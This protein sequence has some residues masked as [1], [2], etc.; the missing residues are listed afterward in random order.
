MYAVRLPSGEFIL[1]VRLSV[2]SNPQEFTM[3]LL[4]LFLLLPFCAFANNDTRPIEFP[5]ITSEDKNHHKMESFNDS[6]HWYICFDDKFFIHDP[7]CHCM[8]SS[9]YVTYETDDHGWPIL[10][11]RKITYEMNPLWEPR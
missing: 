3:R 2:Y 7:D 5:T 9:K 4:L 6:R 8:H 11:S 1:S 10:S